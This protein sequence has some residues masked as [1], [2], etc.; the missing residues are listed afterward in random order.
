MG[1]VVVVPVSLP[2]VSGIPANHATSKSLH[3]P[4]MQNKNMQAQASGSA[5]RSM[6]RTRRGFFLLSAALLLLGPVV[7]FLIVFGLDYFWL[8]SRDGNFRILDVFTSMSVA[9]SRQILGGMGE[10]ITAILGIVITVASIIVQLAATRYTPRITEMFFRDRTNLLII[11]FFIMSAVFCLLVNFSIRG[12]GAASFVPV[13]GSLVV[14]ALMTLSLILI[15]PYFIYVFHFLEP[16]NI[17]RGIERSAS[18]LMARRP[19]EMDVETM[20]VQVVRSVEQLADI[21][22]NAVEQK[23]KGIATS[24]IDALRDLLR[25]YHAHRGRLPEKWFRVSGN[26]RN[27]TDFI[28]MHREVLDEISEKRTWLDYKVL[29]QFQMI[30]NE[31]LNRMRDIN[32]I[33]AIDTRSLGEDAIDSGNQESLR[34]VVKFF[35]TFLRA[36]LNARDVRTAYNVLHQYRLLAEAVLRAGMDDQLLEIAGYFRYYGQVA[37]GMN[38]AFIT[39]TVAYD[40]TSLCELAFSAGA[41]VGDKLL[42]VLLEVDKEAEGEAQEKSLRGVRK[43]QIKMATYFLLH[44]DYER[45]HRIYLDM[46][47]EPI[48]RIRSIRA[49]LMSV[50]SKDFWEVIDRGENFD[51]LH[52]DRRAMLPEFFARFPQLSREG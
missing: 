9:D 39:E 15:A 13:A 19:A 18:S 12:D 26:L 44:E 46:Q 34:L 41:P 49:E 29:R 51:Y 32:Y 25:E 8:G 37:F 38:I 35:N 36:T 50:E 43:A 14:V 45:A 17:V 42:D 1:T 20:Q 30:Y 22:V 2:G 3:I 16:E 23:D 28:S 24:A 10:V 48:D 21:A 33:V 40:L 52:P 5:G 47:N 11:A 6:A 7:F 31:S 27:N 4:M